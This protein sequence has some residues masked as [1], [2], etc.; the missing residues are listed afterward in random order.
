MAIPTDLIHYYKNRAKEYEQIYLKPERQADLEKAAGIIR[1]LF[2]GKMVYEV[3]CGTGYW[4]RIIAENAKQVI[5][6]DI[7]QEVIDI[8][9]QKKYFKENVKFELADIFNPQSDQKH[10]SLFGGF[11]WSHIFI[12]DLEKFMGCIH[13]QV[14]PG[15]LI[16]FIDNKFVPGSS[17]PVSIP[18]KEGNTFQSRKQ[19]DGTTFE[20]LK[21][22]PS[23]DFLRN[24]FTRYSGSYRYYDLPYY[25]IV[26]YK[27]D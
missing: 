15:G 11:I 22:F 7:N 5:A 2:T 14:K 23:E 10:E 13:Q 18:D 17:L 27:S 4:T 6:T 8:A 24:F 19:P 21:N 1:Q 20:V 16:V 12:Q 25:W 26:A 3:A 9:L